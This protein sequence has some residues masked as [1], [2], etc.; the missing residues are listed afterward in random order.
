MSG[1]AFEKHIQVVVGEDEYDAKSEHQIEKTQSHNSQRS[2]LDKEIYQ[3]VT[4][5][6]DKLLTVW[7]LRK[8]MINESRS[9]EREIQT[10]CHLPMS[11]H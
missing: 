9:T 4:M 1:L 3:L 10:K 6:Q 7:D 2:V 8:R 5:S 11:E